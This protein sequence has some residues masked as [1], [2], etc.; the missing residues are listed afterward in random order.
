MTT[1]EAMKLRLGPGFL[2]HSPPPRSATI[3]LRY[4]APPHLECSSVGDW[5]VPDTMQATHHKI[6]V[7]RNAVHRGNTCDD[8]WPDEDTW[9]LNSLQGGSKGIQQPDSVPSLAS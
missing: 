5:I 9:A 8:E 1:K 6:S 4:S 2:V 3:S 7:E